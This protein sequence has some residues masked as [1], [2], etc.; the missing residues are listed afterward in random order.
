M[1]SMRREEIL[2]SVDA[3]LP[4]SS[5]CLNYDFEQNIEKREGHYDD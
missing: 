3:Q 1:S 2:F 4:E 5:Q